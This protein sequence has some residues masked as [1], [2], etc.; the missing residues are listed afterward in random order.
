M[1]EKNEN[2][3]YEVERRDKRKEAEYLNVY[4]YAIAVVR[5]LFDS[6]I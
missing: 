4:F 5:P 3:E 1:H 2:E 6:P